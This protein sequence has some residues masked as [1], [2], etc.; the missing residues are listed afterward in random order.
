MFSTI[1]AS[2]LFQRFHTERV[3]EAFHTESSNIN[4]YAYKGIRIYCIIVGNVSSVAVKTD[5][6][7]MAVSNLFLSSCTSH[8]NATQM[9]SVFLSTEAAMTK[10][11][12]LAAPA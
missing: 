1:M 9:S 6:L 8:Y 11:C 4:M 5:I 3:L 10:Y 2:L 12:M 7:L